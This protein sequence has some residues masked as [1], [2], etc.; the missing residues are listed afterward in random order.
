MCHLPPS[1]ED[2]REMGDQPSSRGFERGGGQRTVEV[3][4]VEPDVAQ[5]AGGRVVTQPG[6]GELVP[7]GQQH[8]RVGG[9]V[10]VPNEIGKGERE[11]E[12]GVN[13][14]TRLRP[15]REIGAGDDIEAADMMRQAL[16]VR[17]TTSVHGA[18]TEGGRRSAQRWTTMFR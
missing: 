8:Q 2:E 14:L 16:E 6:K 11:V 3:R 1:T 13:G 12:G 5:P 4:L 15:R 9:D 18:S 10:P 17:H 7:G